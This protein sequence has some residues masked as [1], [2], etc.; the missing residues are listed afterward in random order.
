MSFQRDELLSALFETVR[1][2]P[3][4]ERLELEAAIRTYTSTYPRTTGAQAPPLLRALFET[5]QRAL[6]FDPPTTGGPR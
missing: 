6:D 2:A 5:M 3:E 1:A 4:P